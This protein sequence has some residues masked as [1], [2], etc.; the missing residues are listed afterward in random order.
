MGGNNLKP[1]QGGGGGPHGASRYRPGF[2]LFSSQFRPLPVATNQQQK[3]PPW[4]PQQRTPGR[5]FI[6]TVATG[7]SVKIDDRN[8]PAPRVPA[9][10][11][12]RGQSL[13]RYQLDSVA[14]R[15]G[16]NF[17]GCLS[18]GHLMAEQS[19]PAAGRFKRPAC[20]RACGPAFSRQGAVRGRTAW[21]RPRRHLAD[22]LGTPSLKRIDSGT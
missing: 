14:V 2:S 15:A 19:E 17:L 10:T 3:R 20:G 4:R 11:G 1:G 16:N 18:A 5:C 7:M 12:E 6:N 22:K 21:P 13:Y 9:A 8:R